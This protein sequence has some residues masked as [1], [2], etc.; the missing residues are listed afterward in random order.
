MP[1]SDTFDREILDSL[2][3]GLVTVSKE[4]KVT[5]FNSAAARMTGLS[6]E[7]VL[8]KP[9]NHVCGSELCRFE[10][11]IALVLES[12]KNLTDFETRVRSGNGRSIPVK[13]NAAVLRRGT[14]EPTGAVISFRDMTELNQTESHLNSNHFCGIISS[15]KEMTDIFDLILE[16]SNSD[17]TVLIQGETGTGKEMVANAIQT[18][19]KRKEKRYVK[20]NCSVLPPPLLTS[21]LF[22]HARGAFTDAV[23]QRIGRFELANHGTLFLDEISEMSLQMQAQL[24]RVLQEGTFERVGESSTRSV[25]VR[26]IAATNINIE[27]A[28]SSGSFREDL[29]YRLNVIPIQLPPLRDRIED[30]PHLVSHFIEKFS[31]LYKKKIIAIDDDALNM[32]MCYAWPGNIR[33]LENALEFAFVRSRRNRSLCACSLPPYL[34]EEAIC[35]NNDELCDPHQIKNTDLIQLLIKHHW[36]QTKVARVLGVN[37]TTIWRRL[38]TMGMKSSTG[39][40]GIGS[41]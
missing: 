35:P 21:E 11:P 12:G 4:F 34:R 2:H 16:F 33:E 32:L 27:Q 17:A 29:L 19:S 15:C 10:C 39:A 24:L 36:N 8:G 14:E 38:K 5:F 30:I 6:P 13:L 7:N 26:I 23:R 3:E 31:I 9:C 18:T 41:S 25:N 40:S 1:L 28:V 20:V 22:G 37:R